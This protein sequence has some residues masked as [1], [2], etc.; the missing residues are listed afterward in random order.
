MALF[1]SRIVCF[2]TTCIPPTCIYGWTSKPKNI[3]LSKSKGTPHRPVTGFIRGGLN[4]E[5][6]ESYEFHDRLGPSFY[7][8]LL[9]HVRD[10]IA[11]GFFADEKLLGDFL[12]RFVLDQQL[13]N[14]PFPVRQQGL[15]FVVAVQMCHPSL[16]GLLE[17]EGKGLSHGIV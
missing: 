15:P 7:V 1:F 9:H 3:P 11:D 4:F 12:G 13:E 2:F 17:H 6:A 8:Q 5:I 14:F 10:M 16:L